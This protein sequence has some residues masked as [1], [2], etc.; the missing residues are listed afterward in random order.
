MEIGVRLMRP[1]LYEELGLTAQEA[2]ELAEHYIKSLVEKHDGNAET[3]VNQTFDAIKSYGP[4]LANLP[5]EHPSGRP[6][7]PQRREHGVSTLNGP[8]VPR[9]PLAA[10]EPAQAPEAAERVNS[11]SQRF[12]TPPDNLPASFTYQGQTYEWNGLVWDSD[13]SVLP[14][15]KTKVAEKLRTGELRPIRTANSNLPPAPRSL[16]SPW[17]TSLKHQ[18]WLNQYRAATPQERQ[19]MLEDAGK[20]MLEN[21]QPPLA[22]RNGPLRAAKARPGQMTLFARRQPSANE[23]LGPSLFDSASERQAQQDAER[24][25]AQLLGDQLTAQLKSGLGAKPTKLKSAQNRN[26]FEGEGPEQGGLFARREETN[27]IVRQILASA[28]RRTPGTSPESHGPGGIGEPGNA[29]ERPGGEQRRTS[30]S[31]GENLRPEIPERDIEE[32]RT[33]DDLSGFTVESTPLFRPNLDHSP[34]SPNQP[35]F[36]QHAD[37]KY[38]KLLEDRPGHVYLNL[39]ARMLVQEAGRRTG[40]IKQDFYGASIPPSVAPVIDRELERMESEYGPI[41]RDKIHQIR[42]AIA[43]AYADSKFVSLIDGDARTA[44]E[45]IRAT[46]KEEEFHRQQHSLM[47]AGQPQHVDIK[48]IIVRSPEFLRAFQSMLDERPY[49]SP[50]EAAQEV[51]ATIAAGR[52]ADPEIGLT[53]EEAGKAF[54]EYYENVQALHGAPMREL[55]RYAHPA[56]QRAVLGDLY[57]GILR[58]ARPNNTE[59]R[60]GLEPQSSGGLP[61]GPGGIGETGEGPLFRPSSL[62]KPPATGAAAT[63]AAVNKKLSQ[64]ERLLTLFNP[65]AE[66]TFPE[67]SESKQGGPGVWISPEGKTIPLTGENGIA[68]HGQTA[69]AMTGDTNAVVASTKLLKNGYI[70]VRG[71]AIQTGKPVYAHDSRLTKALIQAK[72]TSQAEQSGQVNIETPEGY[73]AVPLHQTGMF[74]ANPQA[75][76]RPSMVNMIRGEYG[77]TPVGAPQISNMSAWVKAMFG[78]KAEAVNYS[79]MGAARSRYGAGGNLSQ[80]EEAEPEAAVAFIRA[81]ASRSQATQMIRFAMPAM[82]K[83]LEG[84]PVS[85][86]ELILAYM[87]SRLMGL[88]GRWNDFAD[89]SE[90]ANDKDLAESYDDR[91]AQLLGVIEDKAG[92]PNDLAET[93]AAY[94]TGP[95]GER[96]D[97]LDPQNASHYEDLRDF[98]A[99][100]FREAANKVAEVMDP[101]WFQTVSDHIKSDPKVALAHEIYKRNFEG[102]MASNHAQNEGVFSNALGPLNTYYPLI[103]QGRETPRPFGK[104][105]PYRAPKNPSNRFATGLSEQYDPSLPAFTEKLARTLRANDKAAAINELLS[106]GIAQKPAKGQTSVIYKNVEYPGVIK[107]VS[108][109]RS[110][111]HNGKWIHIPAQHIILPTWAER[112]LRPILEGEPMDP[113]AVK[114]IVHRLN[115]MALVGVAEMAYHSAGLV[116]TLVSNTPFLGSGVMD[117][118]LSTTPF[119]K[120]IASVFKL[121]ATDPTDEE[122]LQALKE[123]SQIG[124]LPA[125]SGKVTWNKRYAELTGAKLDRSS[126]GPMLYG[127]KGLDTRARVLMWQVAKAV[128]PDAAPLELYHFINQLGNYTPELQSEIERAVKGS[129]FAPFATAGLTRLQ[130]GIHAWTLNGPR[131]GTGFKDHLAYRF[132]SGALGLIAMWALLHKLL[133]GEWPWENKNTK[134]LDLPVEDGHGMIGDMR[135]SWIGNKLWG[136][137]PEVGHVGLA[138][139]NPN[140]M[141]AAHLFGIPGAWRTNQL[142]GNTSQDIEAAIADTINAVGH[143]TIG[144]VVRAVFTGLFGRE[145]YLTG[146]RDRQG[147]LGP[148]LM[149][150]IPSKLKPGFVGGFA[151]AVAPGEPVRRHGMAAE[152]GARMAKAATHLNAFA[153]SMGEA[154]GMLGPDEGKK[155]NLWFRMITDLSMPTLFGRAD[156]TRY[157]E[158]ELREQRRAVGQ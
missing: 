116:G 4:E 36:F 106:T 60:Q 21:F 102:V 30:E 131:L 52:W 145:T 153:D 152:T 40:T 97:P 92:L 47:K 110:I 50:E 1:G 157:K 14:F 37:A 154:T 68:T 96:L 99:Q 13:G 3:I 125:K 17:G 69:M 33:R 27:A 138:F 114:T 49:L 133:E 141:R 28:E 57:H 32:W 20:Y 98:L 151:P 35:D 90:T 64:A 158:K 62:N 9:N 143:P 82:K 86:D 70:R 127:P 140:I 119:T 45:R 139:F 81:A 137:G 129:G 31:A 11:E 15:G 121:M 56:I 6:G 87:Q 83:A 126:L 72:T 2:R 148:Q 53:K 71:N 59:E 120:R 80:I 100:T 75:Y 19:Q 10:V 25:E 142:G 122:S 18:Q 84:S 105:N 124:A 63:G 109:D 107:K 55:V 44:V 128:N 88:R 103:A 46:R 54:K 61:Q 73:A 146:L 101:A 94:I 104:A 144:P 95:F 38:E 23:D 85:Y 111:L 65:T 132:M 113:D 74:I 5:R 24:H 48:T 34:A 58:R 22:Y 26:L 41:L 130:N 93:A 156:T 51:A 115:M 29:P 79:G 91:L 43:L 118:L 134:F 123:M 66:N 149:P 89:Q 67:S 112:E 117:K 76:L 108:E 12:E 136:E 7:V 16:A 135:H 150:S 8:P 42:G 39:P 155:G 77:G 147:K 78:P